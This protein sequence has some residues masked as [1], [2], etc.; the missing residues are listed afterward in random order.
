MAFE[1]LRPLRN[2]PNTTP[3]QISVRRA[4]KRR[5]MVISFDQ[6]LIAKLGWKEGEKLVA[7]RG[8][9]NHFGLLML[10]RADL[11]GFKIGAQSRYRNV[12][13]ESRDRLGITLTD[14]PGLDSIRHRPT[15]CHHK[16]I[17]D[18]GN[19]EKSLV[20]TVPNWLEPRPL[21]FEDEPAAARG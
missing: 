12:A 14:W 13:G 15:G 17:D 4:A 11:G 5:R 19:G 2:V 10:S 21:K 20:I 1:K 7:A 9:G 18:A 8:S 6:K 3:V 16:I